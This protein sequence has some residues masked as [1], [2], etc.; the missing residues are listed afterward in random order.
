M[1]DCSSCKNSPLNNLKLVGKAFQRTPC[2][3]CVSEDQRMNRPDKNFVEFDEVLHGHLLAVYEDCFGDEAISRVEL[4]RIMRKDLLHTGKTS[5]LDDQI[6]EIMSG[7]PVPSVRELARKLKIPQR[8]ACRKWLR[9]KRLLAIEYI[10]KA[11]K[12]AQYSVL[13]EGHGVRK[14]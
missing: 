3:A 7:D 12:M 8:T 4:F 9:I 1:K 11:E 5:V 10:K 13:V 6:L 14:L 2:F